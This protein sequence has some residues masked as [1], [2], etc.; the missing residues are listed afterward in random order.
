[1]ARPSNEEANPVDVHLLG[2]EAIVHVPNALAQ[3][4]QNSGGPQRKGAG[5][6]RAFITVH[7]YSVLSAKLSCKPLCGGRHDQLMEQRPTYRAGFALYITTRA[8]PSLSNT[9]PSWLNR[10]AIDHE[11]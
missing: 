2:A 9:N 3:L 11:T 7:S 8:S 6:H 1:M 5:F 10:A 4:V